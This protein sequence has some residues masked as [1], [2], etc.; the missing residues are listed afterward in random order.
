M[1]WRIRSEAFP[2]HPSIHTYIHTDRPS[3]RCKTDDRGRWLQD[4]RPYSFVGAW[5][6]A[7]EQSRMAMVG[8]DARSSRCVQESIIIRK[9]TDAR[10]TP[11]KAEVGLWQ[12]SVEAFLGAGEKQGLLVVSLVGIGIERVGRKSRKQTR[13]R[14]WE[15]VGGGEGRGGVSQP[16][17]VIMRHGLFVG[18]YDYSAG[19]PLLSYYSSPSC[20]S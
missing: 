14:S 19:R 5:G 4:E 10:E 12:K 17:S 6:R 11:C 3:V 20:C 8:G 7:G 13:K 15:G 9:R 1:C 2:I 18:P 16:M